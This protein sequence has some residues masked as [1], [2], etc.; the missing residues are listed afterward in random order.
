[1]RSRAPASTSSARRRT[2]TRRSRSARPPA[3]TSPPPPGAPAPAPKGRP[4]VV[5][6]ST[7][8]PRALAHLLPQLPSPLGN[9]TLIVQHMPKGFTASL[10][11]RLDRP[12]KLTVREARGG[13]T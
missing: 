5:A 6:T 4:V 9:G 8:G 3:P 2:A 12:S 10:A 1:M 7:G 13:E 11:E